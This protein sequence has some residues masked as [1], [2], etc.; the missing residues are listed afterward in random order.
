[1]EDFWD[2]TGNVNEVNTKFLK[3]GKKKKRKS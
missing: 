2:S 1:M 3:K